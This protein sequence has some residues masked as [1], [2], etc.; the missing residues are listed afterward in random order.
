MKHFLSCDRL[1][2]FF[3]VLFVAGLCGMQEDESSGSGTDASRISLSE[4]LNRVNGR[5]MAEFVGGILDDNATQ[6]LPYS[7]C[8]A[9][10][11][12]HGGKELGEV[13]SGLKVN[14]DAR[15][16]EARERDEILTCYPLHL[17]AVRGSV[18]V[19]RQLLSDGK[20]DVNLRAAHGRTPLHAAVAYGIFLVSSRSCG[21]FTPRVASARRGACSIA[22]WDNMR[23]PERMARRSSAP[24]VLRGSGRVR[25]VEGECPKHASD[26]A[27]VDRMCDML[28]AMRMGR[29]ARSCTLFDWRGTQFSKNEWTRQ[30]YAR[31]IAE[32][33][34]S[35]GAQRHPRDDYMQTPLQLAALQHGEESGFVKGLRMLFGP[36]DDDCRHVDS[37]SVSPLT[38][39]SD[40]VRSEDPAWCCG[41][42]VSDGEQSDG[43]ATHNGF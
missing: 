30:D 31:H 6:I 33:L 29:R 39:T 40:L 13:S 26:E 14:T 5:Q 15:T 25:F 27:P 2:I 16:L 42:S 43:D 28:R 35:A 24:A 18:L 19:M 7:R 10:A 36:D 38:D 4:A 9:N 20:C 17:A 34:V 3:C 12:L 41:D 11:L 21:L 22:Q 37:R 8:Y 32:L 23:R 1:L